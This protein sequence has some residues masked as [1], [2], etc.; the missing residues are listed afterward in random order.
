MKF[1]KIFLFDIIEFDQPIYRVIKRGGIAIFSVDCHSPLIRLCR[2]IKEKLKIGEVLHPFSF[3]GKEIIE[4]TSNS[5]L[6]VLYVVTEPTIWL[7]IL[8]N[9]IHD[10][11]TKK[12]TLVT[13]GAILS[14]F[15]RKIARTKTFFDDDGKFNPNKY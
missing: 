2:N 11:D 4:K 9:G 7:N 3:S 1:E 14:S 8:Q 5:N 10:R 12:R 13:I 6:H 15:W